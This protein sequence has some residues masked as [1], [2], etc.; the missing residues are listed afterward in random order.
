MR[1]EEEKLEDEV[2]RVRLGR[3]GRQGSEGRGGEWKE[4]G[5]KIR[6]INHERDKAQ[7][8]IDFD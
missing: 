3:R 1:R 4:V 6:E 2:S 8:R 7:T 5:G